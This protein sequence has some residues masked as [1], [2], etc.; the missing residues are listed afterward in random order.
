[1]CGSAAWCWWAQC[2]ASAGQFHLG[3]AELLPFGCCDVCLW[4]DEAKAAVVEDGTLLWLDWVFGKISWLEW[5][6]DVC[7]LLVVL[8]LLR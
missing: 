5:E 2:S 8:C 1:M 3:S 7:L 6:M 4:S